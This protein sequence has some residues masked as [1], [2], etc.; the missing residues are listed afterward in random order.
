MWGA[1]GTD[2]Q[3]LPK[4]PNQNF[5]V[6][7]EEPVCVT[8]SPGDRDALAGLGFKALDHLG[9]SFYPCDLEAE[10]AQRQG[11]GLHDLLRSLLATEVSRSSTFMG[12]ASGR[13]A[14]GGG[15]VGG[16]G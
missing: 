13:G 16:G 11:N 6:Q 3:S 14:R 5:G 1:D 12:D 15:T 9:S 2:S 7:R 10:H 8:S 4:T